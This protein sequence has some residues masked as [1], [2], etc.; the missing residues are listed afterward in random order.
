MLK[1]KGQ[2]SLYDDFIKINKIFEEILG[3]AQ[4]HL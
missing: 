1:K 2:F 4:K 3:S